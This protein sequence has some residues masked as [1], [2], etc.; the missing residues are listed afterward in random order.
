[1][2]S[3]KV[4]NHK[5]II[6]IKYV[7]LSYNDIQDNINRFLQYYSVLIKLSL[8]KIIESLCHNVSI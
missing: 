3:K 5:F 8:S 4:E 6:R 2:F 1:M 7:M